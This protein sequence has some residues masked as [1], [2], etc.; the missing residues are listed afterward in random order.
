MENLLLSYPLSWILIPLMIHRVLL[1]WGIQRL[2]LARRLRV[3]PREAEFLLCRAEEES[4][5]AQRIPFSSALA[6]SCC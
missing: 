1:F 3:P 2:F 5:W 6:D 4:A